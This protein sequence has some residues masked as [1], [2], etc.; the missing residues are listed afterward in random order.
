V[1]KLVNFGTERGGEWRFK[2]V[3]N[4]RI[5]ERQLISGNGPNIAEAGGT[6]KAIVEPEGR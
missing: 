6:A 1:G 2:L 3:V 4:P 5:A